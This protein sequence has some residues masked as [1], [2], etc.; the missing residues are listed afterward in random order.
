[1]LTC[2]YILGQ[3]RIKLIQ[4]SPSFEGNVNNYYL[5]SS[6]VFH[7]N[8]YNWNQKSV[9]ERKRF[10]CYCKYLAVIS[11]LLPSCD[12]ASLKLWC[13]VGGGSVRV[14]ITSLNA[15]CLTVCP[16]GISDFCCSSV[17]NC[18][19]DWTRPRRSS[20]TE[21]LTQQ[22]ASNHAVR[23]CCDATAQ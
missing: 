19:C 6:A 13:T 11:T 4:S 1:M 18:L 5:V 20:L 21:C 9:R 14:E 2:F 3:I 16:K 23:Y 7:S 12:G 22:D 17:F 8:I 15:P 10:S